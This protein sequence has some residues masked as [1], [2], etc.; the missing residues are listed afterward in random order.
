ML[1]TANR[2][3]QRHGYQRMSDLWV[4]LID[5]DAVLMRQHNQVCICATVTIIWL[6]GG[7]DVVFFGV[8][9][10]AAMMENM[11]FFDMVWRACFRWNIWPSSATGDTTYG[12]VEIIRALADAGIYA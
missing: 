5:P 1:A 3:I 10:T 4:S 8:L 11:L 6:M 7:K 9:V 12:T 2:A